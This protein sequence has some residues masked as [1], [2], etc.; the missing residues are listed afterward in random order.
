MCRWNLIADAWASSLTL[1]EKVGLS[2]E[3]TTYLK[4]SYCRSKTL[5]LCIQRMVIDEGAQVSHIDVYPAENVLNSAKIRL[6]SFK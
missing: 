4:T 5:K 2:P 3:K 1:G 6:A